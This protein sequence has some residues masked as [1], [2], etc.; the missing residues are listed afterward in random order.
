MTTHNTQGRVGQL[1]SRLRLFAPVAP[2]AHPQTS[3]AKLTAQSASSALFAAASSG[4]AAG[5]QAY[6]NKKNNNRQKEDY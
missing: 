5:V 4:D 1:L 6:C 2:A 3:H